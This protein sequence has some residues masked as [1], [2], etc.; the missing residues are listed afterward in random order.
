MC[1]RE[2]RSKHGDVGVAHEV[3]DIWI[4]SS[5]T[6]Q[7]CVVFT[8]P[9][10]CP[11]QGRFHPDLRLR[12]RCTARLAVTID[13]GKSGQDSVHTVYSSHRW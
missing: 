5:S 4:P 6:V 2:L 9:L 8:S 1:L 10:S 11:K 13:S 7:Y 3:P 12:L